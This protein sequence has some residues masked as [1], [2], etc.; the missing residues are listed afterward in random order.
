MQLIPTSKEV[1][2]DFFK[3]LPKDPGIYKF[4]NIKKL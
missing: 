3:D 4:L 2:K 1:L